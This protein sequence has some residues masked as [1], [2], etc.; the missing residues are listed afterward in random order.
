[1]ADIAWITGGEVHLG[2]LDGDDEV[3]GSRF[4][5]QV[6][7]NHASIEQRNAWKHG[8]RA[9]AMQNPWST[10]FGDLPGQ[11]PTPAAVV[12]LTRGRTPGE[13]AY[14]L[15]APEVGALLVRDPSDPPDEL[16]LFHTNSTSLRDLDVDPA[17]DDIVLSIGDGMGAS[18]ALV[19]QQGG[20]IREL[21]EGHSLDEAPTWVPGARAIVYQSAGLAM[22]QYGPVPKRT[23]YT[24]ERLDLETGAIETLAGAEDA[25]F[26][27]PRIDP[28]GTLWFL[29]RPRKVK[30]EATF[31]S[32][33]WGLV[34]MPMRLGR[35]I[36]GWLDL[37]TMMYSGK[38]L[39]PSDGAEGDETDPRSEMIRAQLLAVGRADLLQR[40]AEGDDGTGAVLVRRA[41]DGTETEVAT[42]V[43]DY[44]LGT[45]GALLWC[46]SAG[47]WVRDGD[48]APR[49]LVEQTWVTRVTWMS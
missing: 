24:I 1:M 3:W 30:K 10:G 39:L 43:V 19:P 35:A 28:D 31:A 5:D 14:V 7:R 27:R 36:L 23:P 21:T 34:T 25:D 20:R 17:R 6:R 22:A 11:G 40:K 8:Q 2:T 16:R 44:D 33:L 9:D 13:L 4:A 29:R 18:L 12:D 42:D 41:P 38:R 45:D 26:L 15:A 47:V 37:F 46:D 49:C 48:A 32:W